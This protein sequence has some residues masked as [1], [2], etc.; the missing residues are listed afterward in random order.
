MLFRSHPGGKLRLECDR[1][2]GAPD[3]S[4]RAWCADGSLLACGRLKSGCVVGAWK[5]TRDGVEE[6]RESGPI[7]PRPS[8]GGDWSPA[9]SAELPGWTAVETWVAEMSSPL[10]PAPV[11]SGDA[12]ATAAKAPELAP[13]DAT[14]IPARAQPWTEYER[15]VLPE[16]SEL[17]GKGIDAYQGTPALRTSGSGPDAPVARPAD[18]VGRTLPL[19]RFSAANGSATDLDACLGRQNVLVTILRG[20]GGQVCVYCTAQTKALADFA[21]RFAA[22]NTKVVVVFPGPAS[23]LEAFREAY[24]R[25]YGPGEKLPFDLLY[26]TD[27]ALTRALHIEDNIA[28]P[29]SLLLDR[30]GIVR[31][32]HVARDHADRPS[33]QE[34]LERIAALPK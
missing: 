5:F 6:D 31:W 28:V 33:A 17:Y 3:G 20:F 27:L 30:R 21:E 13:E 2:D 1:R 15:R 18:L 29:T 19:R 25:T 24:R 7:R 4:A 23:G 32:C 22:L 14:G 9:E 12:P 11:P 34:I 10:Q 16:L 26:D 8:F